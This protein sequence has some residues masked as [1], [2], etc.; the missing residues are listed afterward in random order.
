MYEIKVTDLDTGNTRYYECDYIIAGFISAGISNL[1]SYGTA[2]EN[3]RRKIIKNVITDG[4][5]KDSQGVRTD[6]K[7]YHPKENENRPQRC[8]CLKELYC[9]TDRCAWYK[10]KRG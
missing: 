3:S 7:Y 1:F 8:E 4:M 5:K 9:T 6:C 2:S 10:Q